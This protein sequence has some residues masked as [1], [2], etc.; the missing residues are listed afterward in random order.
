MNRRESLLA[1]ICAAFGIGS[2]PAAQ[3]P[4]EYL[5]IDELPADSSC[6]LTLVIKGTRYRFAFHSLKS[7]WQAWNAAARSPYSPDEFFGMVQGV[8]IGKAATMV[9]IELTNGRWNVEDIGD[10]Y[11][12]TRTKDSLWRRFNWHTGVR[13]KII[14]IAKAA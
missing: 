1:G 13:E 3:Q 7:R 9:S 14:S 6:G 12:V 5:T 8:L 4:D 10:C 11:F 2:A